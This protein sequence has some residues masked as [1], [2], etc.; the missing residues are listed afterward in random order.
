MKKTDKLFI[1]EKIKI[2]FQ[3]RDDTFTKKLAYII[4]YDQTGKLRKEASWNN[5]RDHKIQDIDIENIP[6]QGFVLNKSIQRNG[7]Y[8]GSGRNMIRVYDPRDLEFEIT[9]DNLLYILMG[10]DCNRRELSGKYVYAWAGTEL[11]LLPCSSEE[12]K[13]A[14][15][16]TNNQ[17]LKSVKSKE[18]VIGQ[19]YYNKRDPE[20]TL[21]YIGKRNI[22]TEKY[23]YSYIEYKKN[24]FE[25]LNLKEDKHVFHLLKGNNQY[26]AY[27]E[28]FHNIITNEEKIE[29]EEL[30]SILQLYNNSICAQQIV[31]IELKPKP[32]QNDNHNF[33]WINHNNRFLY[34]CAVDDRNFNNYTYPYTYTLAFTREL[35]LLN[36]KLTQTIINEPYPDISVVRLREWPV[37]CSNIDKLNIVFN[38]IKVNLT[39]NFSYKIT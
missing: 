2:G 18:L 36:N 9:S 6:T 37:L 4:Y 31:N 11:V 23:S 15:T 5:W 33:G 12:Y 29:Q 14:K 32:K 22:F 3:N 7:S 35:K 17:S 20:Q 30:D 19:K 21:I 25:D 38:N 24:K 16:Y 39:N 10:D 27:I 26:F 13:K 34:V 1:P 8:F 28:K